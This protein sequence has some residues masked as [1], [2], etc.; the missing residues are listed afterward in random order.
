MRRRSPRLAPVETKGGTGWNEGDRRPSDK[1]RRSCRDEWRDPGGADTKDGDPCRLQG[2]DRV[3]AILDLLAR[4]WQL[5]DLAEKSAAHGAAEEHRAS[6]PDG[7][8]AHGYDRTGAG[9]SL[10]ARAEASRYGKPCR[11]TGG[12]ENRCATHLRKLALRVGETVHLGVLHKTRVV[13][14]DKV[15]PINRRVCLS[16]RANV[17]PIYC[18]SMGKAMLAFLPIEE[19]ER[20]IAAVN[21]QNIHNQDHRFSRRTTRFSGAYPAKGLRNRR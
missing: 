20:V 6:Y 3:V 4:C 2:L 17:N 1:P 18:T 15:E 19:A 12:F 5:T 8:R 11:R 13:Y 16:S 7:A 21:F 9:E 10:S 14:V